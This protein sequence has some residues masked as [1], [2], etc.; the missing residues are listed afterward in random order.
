MF[1]ERIPDDVDTGLAERE[2][3]LAAIRAQLES[4][5]ETHTQRLAGL[6]AAAKGGGDVFTSS[7]LAASSRKSLAEITRALRYLNEGRYGRCEDC[8]QEIPLERLEIRPEARY[9]VRCQQK[10]EF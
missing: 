5:F 6:T 9:C 10:H 8:Q 7:A 1:P 4:Q 3:Q 2:A